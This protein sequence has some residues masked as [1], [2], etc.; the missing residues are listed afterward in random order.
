VPNA[1]IARMSP[2]F[3]APSA[4][5]SQ[6][7]TG[8]EQWEAIRSRLEALPRVVAVGANVHLMGMAQK[9]G[10]GSVSFVGVGVEPERERRMGFETKL[11]GG[12]SLPDDA[13][14]EGAGTSKQYDFSPEPEMLLDR[15]LPASVRMRLFQCFIEAIVSEHVARMVAMKAATDAAN[16]MIKSLTRQYNRARQTHITMELLDIIG[17]VNALEG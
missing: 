7:A 3:S 17:G 5:A 1:V 9:P 12:E 10:G 16:D 2:S 6:I 14:A 11:R 15:L 13:P 8:I 4:R